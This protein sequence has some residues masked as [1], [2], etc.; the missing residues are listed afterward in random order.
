MCVGKV[1]PYQGRQ[2]ITLGHET[3]RELFAV[4]L[5]KFYVQKEDGY[6]YTLD[7]AAEQKCHFLLLSVRRFTLLLKPVN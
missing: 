3:G 7:V 1:L 2:K 6:W 4:T 5:G